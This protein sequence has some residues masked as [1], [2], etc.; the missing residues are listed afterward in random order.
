[1]R[2]LTALLCIAVGIFLA[3]RYPD[4]MYSIYQYLDIAWNWL[5]EQF[6]HLR[7]QG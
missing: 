3:F 5:V 2:L 1:M 4:T 7:G 6:N